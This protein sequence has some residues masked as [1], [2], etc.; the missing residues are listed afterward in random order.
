GGIHDRGETTYTNCLFSGNRADDRAGGL[1]SV[2]R[3]TTTIVNC[4]FSGNSANVGGA[5]S[6]RWDATISMTNSVV[7]NNY[8]G[9][10]GTTADPSASYLGNSA[11]LSATNSLIQHYTASEFGGTGN[12]DG[13][14]ANNDPLF[15][16]PIDP[17]TAPTTAGNLRVPVHSPVANAGVGSA[18]PESTDLDG[19]ARI[20]G[21][22]I[23]L[24]A[25]EN[26]YSI[27]PLESPD[28]FLVPQGGDLRHSFYLPS[29]FTGVPDAWKLI[30]NSNPALLSA[31]VASEDA[32]SF[33][34]TLSDG[35]TDGAGTTIDG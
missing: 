27:L 30:S 13:T 17:A 20:V 5:L 23:D 19:S 31:S 35:G 7:W 28:E 22:G 33:V 14:D 29:R 4:T 8:H 18:N 26:D 3:A 34:E 32:F 9:T 6:T 2:D 24:G 11:K 21:S 10:P 15:F 16:D 1:Y 25:F 12:L